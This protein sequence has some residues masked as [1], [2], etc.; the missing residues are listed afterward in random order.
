[1]PGKKNSVT[2]IDVAKAAGV[3]VSTVSRVLNNKDDVSDATFRHVSS[4][5]DE[6]AYSSSL[7]AK[8][9]RSRMTNVI[10]L[11]MPDVEDPFSIL[12]MKG[13]NRAIVELDYDLLIYTNGEIGRSASTVTEQQYVTLLNS[14]VTDGVIVVTPVAPAYSSSSPVVTVDPNIDNPKGPKVV[15]TNFRGAVEATEHLIAFGHKRIGYISGRVELLCTQQ[16]LEGYKAALSGA[17]ICI[18][19]QL[20]TPG[21]FTTATGRIRAR[22]LLSMDDPPTAIF[23]S[24]DQTAIGVYKEAIQLGISIPENLSVIGFDNIPESSFYD[25]TTVDQFVD[26][27]GY[28]GARMLHDLIHGRPLAAEREIIETQLIVRSSAQ[29]I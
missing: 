12:V 7:A 26:R 5:I 11:I 8:S 17:G 29:P 13:V 6:L 9:M 2:I 24:N 23:A 21:D 3:S 20:I 27:M 14:S 1:M 19:P 22:Q 18:D 25:L 10:G 28:I 16:R 4:V 15:S